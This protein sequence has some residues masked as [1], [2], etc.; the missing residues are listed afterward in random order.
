MKLIKK[1]IITS[2]LL[3]TT[4]LILSVRPTMEQVLIRGDS[5][6]NYT[7]EYYDMNGLSNISKLYTGFLPAPVDKF[8]ELLDERNG[9]LFYAQNNDLNGFNK[10]ADQL[11]QYFQEAWHNIYN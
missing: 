9:L 8:I 11:D 3:S 4:N 5:I 2:I 10:I 7:R 1:I 6:F